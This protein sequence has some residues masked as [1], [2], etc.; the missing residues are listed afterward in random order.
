M[1][2]IAVNDGVDSI[3]ATDVDSLDTSFRALLYDLYSRD[4]SRKV[5]SALRLRAQRGDCLSTYAPY[6]YTKDPNKKNHL[7]ID[8]PAAEI[9]RRVF[10][11]ASDG[12]STVQIAQVLNR[13]YV[14][15]PMQ[16]KRAAGYPHMG[17]N[18]VGA[19]NFWTATEIA[20][21]LRDEQYLGKV[22]YGKRFYD[23]IGNSH[24]VKV[25]R[26][27]WIVTPGAHEPIVSQ[28]EYDRAQASRSN[29]SG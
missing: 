2:F 27:D 10:R 29:P 20:R 18:C 12:Q 6:G 13:E 19:E 3:R 24:S 17:W 25:S 15:T 8:P 22:V 28:D 11:M 1:R 5:R 21:I 7:V 16:V 9:V 4:L 26:K 23:I 14:P